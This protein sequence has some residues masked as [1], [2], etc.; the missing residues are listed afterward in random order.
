MI[1]SQTVKQ[2]S[3]IDFPPLATVKK[4]LL[5]VF[6]M[7]LLIDIFTGVNSFFGHGEAP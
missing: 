6:G 3:K 2:A 5:C 7:E 1:N 4:A